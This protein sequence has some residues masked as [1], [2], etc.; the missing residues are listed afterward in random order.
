VGSNQ[1]VHPEA[2]TSFGRDPELN[3]LK[4]SIELIEM[5][6]NSGGQR[7]LVADRREERVASSPSGRRPSGPAKAVDHRLSTMSEVLGLGVR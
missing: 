2:R 7:K 6:E 5:I 4:L 3:T 1:L